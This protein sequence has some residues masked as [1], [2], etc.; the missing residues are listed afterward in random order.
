[1]LESALTVAPGV[2]LAYIDTGAPEV[3]P[4]TTIFAI[5]G[6]CFTNHIF[7][8]LQSVAFTKGFRF[9]SINR[10]PFKGS[11]PFTA[12]ETNLILN[13]DGDAERRAAF[14]EARG[15]EMASFID[16]FTQ[17]FKLP[18]VSERGEKGGAIL[19]GWSFGT[20]FASAVLAYSATLPPDVRFRLA[21]QLR[22]VVIYDTTPGIMGLTDAPKSWAP[23]I[24]T[25]IPENVRFPMF[26]Q[27]IS[28]YFDH[29]D[30]SKHDLYTLQYVL[31]SIDKVPT[32][33]NMD[34]SEQNNA[35]E[36]GP[37]TTFDFPLSIFFK[38]QLR[39]TFV[40]AFGSPETAAL[41]PNLSKIFIVADRSPPLALT[42]MWAVQDELE[43]LG[44]G[45]DIT[46]KIAKGEN[47]FMHWDNPE[48]ILELIVADV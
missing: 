1:M 22:S 41:F 27:W 6:T 33:F 10:R 20:Q 21:S 11:T 48:K 15:H 5:H 13:V 38:E 37:D 16:I 29:G 18:P 19:F 8:R 46:Y 34:F 17:T 14:M 36:F 39:T 47:H 26:A 24:D 45:K 4:Y 43:R 23:L 12:E 3:S 31:P 35:L 7:K 44:V 9:V 32:I 2:E 28:S 30:Y 25:T 40:K 42:G